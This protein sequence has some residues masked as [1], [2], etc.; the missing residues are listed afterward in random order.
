MLIDEIFEQEQELKISQHP[1]LTDAAMFIDFV[2]LK[3][4][5]L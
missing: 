1:H 4:K 2:T 3:C 5:V